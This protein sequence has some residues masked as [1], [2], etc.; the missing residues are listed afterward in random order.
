VACIRHKR[1]NNEVAVAAAVLADSILSSPF[2]I[3][4]SANSPLKASVV[5]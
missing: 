3:R 2:L 1:H 5:C 4:R